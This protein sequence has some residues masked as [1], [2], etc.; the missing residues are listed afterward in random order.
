[1]PEERRT[2]RGCEVEKDEERDPRERDEDD[3]PRS[4][5]PPRGDRPQ[6]L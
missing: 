5:R 6:E 3:D 1:M 4:I 2:A